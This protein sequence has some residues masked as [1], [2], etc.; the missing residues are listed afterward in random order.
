MYSSNINIQLTTLFVAIT[1][2]AFS[3]T[4]A[5]PVDDVPDDPVKI[6]SRI[7][8]LEEALKKKADK[9]DSAKGFTAKL[10]G[11]IYFDSYHLS[12]DGRSE[13][14][15]F[16][17]DLNYNGIKDLRIGVTGEGYRNYAYKLDLFLANGNTVEIRDVWLSVSDVPLLESVKI[18]HHRV[19]EGISSLLPGMHTQFIFYDGADFINFYRLGIS[20]RHLWAQKRIRFF[21][22]V[23]EFK[24]VAQQFRNETDE[25]VHWGTIANTRLTYMPYISKDK[26]GTID[27][28][29]FMLFGINY[30]YYD[31]NS[32]AQVFN[33]RYGQLFGLLQRIDI[34]NVSA[35]QQ[36]G[37]EFAA[38][39]GPLAAQSEAYIRTYN[40]TGANN[41]VTVW[42]TYLE[43]RIFLT[44]D[45]RRFNADQAIW[46]GVTLKHN[47]EFMKKNDWNFAEHLGA[48]EL[49][50]KWSYTDVSD[51]GR[52]DF[53][54][55]CANR[56]HDFTVGLNWYWNERTRAMF[57]YTR[58]L[59]VDKVGGHSGIDLFA[60]SFRY[61]F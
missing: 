26:D 55:V 56:V 23:F 6:E 21:V 51:C 37:L 59:P 5:Q 16:R 53:P 38:Q 31:V 24:P 1:L 15:S 40:R 43:G 36:V 9:P 8:A 19:E 27:G 29:R 46:S 34:G 33:V 30:G 4:Y 41:D 25:S 22:G 20:S 42:G 11:R 45:F 17:N 18:G 35:Y 7:S 61:Y 60:T 2:Y 32:A 57:N 49:A 10:D 14:P 48:W 39:H 47:L 52:A 12:G 50:V 58:I 28:E 54:G 44:G 13:T 3:A